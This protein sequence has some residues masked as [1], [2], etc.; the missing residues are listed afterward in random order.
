MVNARRLPGIPMSSLIASLKPLS[1][2]LLP[3]ILSSAVISALTLLITPSTTLSLSDFSNPSYT[4][5]NTLL[6]LSSFPICTSH[7]GVSGIPT[8]K[9]NC[10]TAGIAPTPTIALHPCGNLAKTQPSTYAT[11]CPPVINKLCTVTNRP[12]NSAGASSVI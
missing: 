6:A 9:P 12:L 3:P 1:L 2:P 4:F 8:N 5:I 7:L 10:T 11:T